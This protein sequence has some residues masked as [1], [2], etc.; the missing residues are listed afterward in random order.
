VLQAVADAGFAGV[1]AFEFIDGEDG[2][3]ADVDIDVGGAVEWVE[4]KGIVAGLIFRGDNDS[5]VFFGAHNGKTTMLAD[6]GNN[7]FV[8]EQI[9]FFYFFTLNVDV[10]CEPEN[11]DQSGADDFSSDQFCCKGNIV[12][13]VGKFAACF[14]EKLLLF[15]DV[16]FNGDQIAHDLCS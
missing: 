1:V 14:G 5:F 10:A 9:E 12:E 3:D 7:F 4:K 11:V 15:E 16:T 2:A 13:Q 8:G 6:C